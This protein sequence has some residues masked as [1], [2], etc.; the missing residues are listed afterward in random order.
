MKTNNE[1]LN[2][3]DKTDFSG[4]LK[5]VLRQ[6]IEMTAP[7]SD[8]VLREFPVHEHSGTY[9]VDLLPVLEFLL[10]VWQNSVAHSVRL[11][12]LQS[13]LNNWYYFQMDETGNDEI[14]HIIQQ[15]LSLFSDENWQNG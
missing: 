10:L 1:L 11:V 15:K 2:L 5:D 9:S 8:D 12:Y 7:I 4:S 6:I 3:L 13:L 14:A